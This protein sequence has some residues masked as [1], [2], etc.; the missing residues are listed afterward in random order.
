MKIK[1]V[2]LDHQ[3]EALETIMSDFKGI[4]EHKSCS[5]INYEFSNPEIKNAYSN[6]ANLDIKME[7]GTGKTYV[8]S[9]M[10][11]EMHK[12]F[13][14]FK[15]II[16]VPSPAIKEGAYNFL[17][18]RYSIEHFKEKYENTNIEVNILN[19]GD[20][21][22]KA[23][24]KIFPPQLNN[25]VEGSIINSN[26]IQVL[27]INAAMLNSKS[28]SRNDYDQTLL[29]SYSSPLQA[30]KATKPIII[31]DEP[32]RFP[33]D[34]KYYAAVEKLHPQMIVRF[35]ATF[36]EVKKGS[37]K[38]AITINDYYNGSP[39]FELNAIDSFNLGLV[40]DIDIYYPNLTNEQ[41]Q[42]RYRV[43]EVKK[44][45]LIVKKGNKEWVLGIGD[46]LI[47]VDPHFEG[48]IFY[49]GSKTLSNSLEL[50]IGMDLIPGT[51]TSL[52][53]ER[54]LK[55]AIDEHFN[56]EMKN[57][58]R[59]NYKKNNEPKVKTLSLIFIDTIKSYRDNQGWLKETFEKLLRRKLNK[60]INEFK[61]R[62]L[63]RET[64]YLD[65]L[66]CTLNS[67]NSD[68][69]LVHAGYFGEDRGVS[70]EAIQL[71]VKDILKNKEKLLS[72]KDEKGNWIL[73]RFLFSKWTLRE[74]WDNPNVF[75]IA[76][77]RT[78]GSENSK[79]QEVGRGL[80]LPVDELGNRLEKDKLDSSLSFL[81]GF[82][83]KNFAE[84]LIGEINS[85]STIKINKTSLTEEMINH[86]VSV[87]RK[88]DS[89]Y[90]K[91]VLLEDLDKKNIINRSNDFNEEVKINEVIKSGFEWFTEYYPEINTLKLSDGKIR[92]GLS[93][94]R[95]NLIKLNIGKWNKMKELWK[96]LSRRHM[97]IFDKISEES[98]LMFIENI[99]NED[100]IL[101]TQLPER[102]HQSIESDESGNQIIIE[103]TSSYNERSQYIY[104]GYGVFLKKLSLKTNIPI[105]LVHRAL[106]SVLEEKYNNDKRYLSENSLNNILNEF[107]K[108]FEERFSQSYVYEKLDFSST[109]SIFDKEINE[110]KKYINANSLGV[111][112]D[113]QVFED[114]RFLYERPPVRYDSLNPELYLLK[115]KY[116]DKIIAFGN[117]PKKAIQVP[118]YIGGT[119]TPDFIYI[120]ERDDEEVYLIVETKA[121]NMRLSDKV[122]TD[123]QK[124]FF[125]NLE[126]ENLQYEKATNAQFVYDKIKKISE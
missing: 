117:L 90:D 22:S 49:E 45:K 39:N 99:L 19:A 69:Q 92:E 114:G 118:K 54:I 116:S 83:E 25:F 91:N 89:T 112:K 63:P 110:F 16:V 67:L 96:Q 37:G 41:A 75:V 85:D 115:R 21:K 79:I 78:S 15:F 40:K 11:Y 23:G 119:T 102:V 81:I 107:K 66:Q 101:V 4:A 84:K 86:I 48:D 57:F 43:K 71:E 6:N 55:D 27:I 20:F 109:T 77:L 42:N 1:L 80:R 125:D 2:E 7:T 70:E 3:M 76:K 73:R 95:E 68:N 105:N 26:Q 35:G 10:I 38:N 111:Y 17:T 106:I 56:I 46:Y 123:I 61:H 64:E 60:L 104:M 121:E 18:S 33:R 50:D 100:D 65:F 5:K 32:H 34:K 74:G 29:S 126:V 36:P 24:K 87:K 52:Y 93:N 124:Q 88:Y 108:R 28:M 51:F 9:R 72:F 44:D 82:D 30:L 8:Y 62:K 113:E 47:N 31:I 98:L 122:I 53:Q 12:K 14:L 59:D 13:G 97:L 103:D 94:T 58:L 120:I